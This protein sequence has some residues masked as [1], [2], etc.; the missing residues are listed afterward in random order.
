MFRGCLW[1]Y[2]RR[3]CCHFAAWPTVNHHPTVNQLPTANYQ[4]QEYIRHLI[5]VELREDTVVH[6]L[7]KLVKVPWAESEHYILK[8]MMKVRAQYVS[9]SHADIS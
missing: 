5:M 8:C 3:T 9:T 7:R 4:P 1:N 2:E 6:V